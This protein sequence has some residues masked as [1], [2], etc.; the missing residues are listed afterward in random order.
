MKSKTIDL[1][2]DKNI[3][4]NPIQTLQTSSI[5]KIDKEGTSVVLK[6]GECTTYVLLWKDNCEKSKVEK[7]KILVSSSV[8]IQG[9]W[10]SRKFV[11]NYA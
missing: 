10:I 6:Y 3:S 7:Y 1:E 4:Y 2:G 5:V 11:Q 9:N 8:H